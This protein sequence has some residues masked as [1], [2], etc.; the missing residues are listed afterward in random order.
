MLCL[1]IRRKNLILSSAP[2]Q[3]TLH[4]WR[5]RRRRIQA[6]VIFSFFLFFSN[7]RILLFPPLAICSVCSSPS[8]SYF[9]LSLLSKKLPPPDLSSCI[10]QRKSKLRI[11]DRREST[12]NKKQGKGSCSNAWGGQIGIPFSV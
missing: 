12:R 9:P 4:R 3:T 5:R 8:T 6:S 10:P 1:V 7:L 2:G 11:R